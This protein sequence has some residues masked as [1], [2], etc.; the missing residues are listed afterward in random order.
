MAIKQ[1]L[2]MVASDESGATAV[3]YGLIL[4]L[5]ALAS[6]GALVGLAGE[7]NSM[8]GDISTKTKESSEQARN[9]L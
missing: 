6:L 8:W 7:T 5:I 3:E 4:A 1:L 2:K 9:G